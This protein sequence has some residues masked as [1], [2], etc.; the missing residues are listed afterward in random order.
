LDV[1]DSEKRDDD[2]KTDL[3]EGG[4]IEILTTVEE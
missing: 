2:N 4:V 1:L 3:K